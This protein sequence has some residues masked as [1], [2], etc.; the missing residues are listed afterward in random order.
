MK[1]GSKMNELA[2]VIKSRSSKVSLNSQEEGEAAAMAGRG[3]E[4][5][6]PMNRTAAEQMTR[7]P[8]GA[9]AMT[10]AFTDAR[11]SAPGGETQGALNLAG[12]SEIGKY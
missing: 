9:T 1:K 11:P 7:T 3:D 2:E 8:M 5:R 4:S 12:T 10:G 6:D